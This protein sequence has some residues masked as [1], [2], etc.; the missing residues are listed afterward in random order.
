MRDQDRP[1]EDQARGDAPSR[2]GRGTEVVESGADAAHNADDRQHQVGR[3]RDTEEIA[4][5]SA[6]ER[7]QDDGEQDLDGAWM[8]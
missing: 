8:L 2:T 5:D 1:T 7:R 6:I 4:G 3:L